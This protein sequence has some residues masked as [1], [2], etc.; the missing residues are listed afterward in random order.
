MADP[1]RDEL[2]PLRTQ[3]SALRAEVTEIDG[4]LGQAEDLR[5]RRA[6]V[7]AE[8]ADLEERLRNLETQSTLDGLRIASPCKASWDEMTGDARVRFCGHCAKNVFNVGGMTRDEAYAF[9][10]ENAGGTVCM[11]L[12][13]RADGTVMTA[14]CPV[15]QKKKQ[16]R[17]LALVA[18]GIAATVAAGSFITLRASSTM[19]EIPVAGGVRVPQ[20]PRPEPEMGKMVMGEA[21][22]P[23]GTVALPIAP[24]TVSPKVPPPAK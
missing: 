5:K 20:P 18:G 9:L 4:R 23:M 6:D 12:Y 10:R 11:R 15:G 19:G 2:S 8:I 3:L 22:M 7:A 14:D 1:Y 13:R 16:V 17:R 24:P 21:P